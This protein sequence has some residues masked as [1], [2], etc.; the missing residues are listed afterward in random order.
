[1]LIKRY[2]VAPPL[3]HYIRHYWSMTGKPGNQHIRSRDIPDGNPEVII[4]F[5]TAFGRVS[6]G[7]VT[8][9]ATNGA[10]KPQFDQPAIIEQSGD[11]DLLG[12]SFKPEGIYHFVQSAMLPF[13]NEI[14]PIEMLVGESLFD[15]L[16]SEVIPSNRFTLLE[17]FLLK[18]LQTVKTPNALIRESLARVRS[19]PEAV[20]VRQ[21]CRDLKVSI[22]QLER[23]YKQ[24]IGTTPKKLFDIMRI[25]KLLSQ[26]KAA[27]TDWMHLVVSCG[28][29]DQSHLCH[30]F[31]RFTGQTPTQYLAKNDRFSGHYTLQGVDFL[32]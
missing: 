15:Q 16:R 1:M 18:K 10:I 12:I 23:L 4:N 2:P 13:R 8:T 29:H 17:E 11:I 32:Q 25:N 27:P 6:E 5:G 28:Y 9:A 22:K 20:T 31:Q 21:L 30:D 19:C 24:E 3:R 26:V 14:V 7:K